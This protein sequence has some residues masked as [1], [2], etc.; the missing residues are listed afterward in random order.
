MT[1]ASGCTVTW[2]AESDRI[3]LISLSSWLNKNTTAGSV[4]VNLTD[5]S[6]VV[7]QAAS[8]TISGVQGFT[9]CD[10]SVYETGLSGTTTRK[11]RASATSGGGDLV[12][13]ANVPRQLIV[14]DMGLA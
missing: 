6:N 9:H 3:Y 8:Y 11:I 4:E 10:M 1:D 7:K 5:P 2:T 12:G 13:G 14:I